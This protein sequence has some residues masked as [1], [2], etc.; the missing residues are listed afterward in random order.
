VLYAEVLETT[1]AEKSCCSSS[2]YAQIISVFISVAVAPEKK[3][4]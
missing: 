3:Q 2:L 4:R 1:V